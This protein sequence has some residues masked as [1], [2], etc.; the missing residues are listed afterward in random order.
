MHT[1]DSRFTLR[2]AYTPIWG[3][4]SRSSNPVSPTD[5]SRKSKDLRGPKGRRD[6][7]ER[8]DRTPGIHPGSGEPTADAPAVPQPQPHPAL[9]PPD[10]RGLRSTGAEGANCSATPHQRSPG[11][12]LELV[13][14]APGIHPAGKPDDP[15][16]QGQLESGSVVRDLIPHSPDVDVRHQRVE[17]GEP[18]SG[19]GGHPWVCASGVRRQHRLPGQRL[20]SFAAGT[21][22]RRSGTAR[23]AADT[24]RELLTGLLGCT[25]HAWTSGSRGSGG[26]DYAC[27]A[28]TVVRTPFPRQTPFLP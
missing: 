22:N 27:L 17:L 3:S 11:P 12:L 13:Q 6:E 21:M 5:R 9:L 1:P 19:C 16:P 10:R 2:T 7:L 15:C 14:I 18:G 8:E 25:A 26:R 23:S 28:G 4:R 24:S 20:F